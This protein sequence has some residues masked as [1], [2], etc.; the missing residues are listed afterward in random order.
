MPACPRKDVF[1]PDTVGVYHCWNR[2][3]RRAW[4]CGVDPLT[5]ADYEHRRTWIEQ[6]QALLAGLFAI[7]IG[8][9]AELSNH[10][11]L[12]LRNRP[13]VVETWS[14]E[15]VARRVLIINRLT[16]NFGEELEEPS[17]GAIQI[18]LADPEKVAA[19]RR[20]LSDISAFMASLDEYI[21]RRANHEEGIGGTFWEGRFRCRNLEDEAAILVC[22]VYVDL[23]Q[24]RA[25]EAD[26]PEQSRH[27]SAYNRIRGAHWRQD[28]RPAETSLTAD[29]DPSGDA[30]I[31]EGG[32]RDAT[33]MPPDGWLCEL[34]LEE[35]LQ[36]DVGR[37]LSS[38]TPW[39]LTDKGILPIRLP[40]Y[41][42]LLDWT[43]RQQ[44]SGKS[45]CIPESLAPILERLHIRPDRWL[46]T[47]K[48]FETLFGRA[49]GRAENLARRVAKGGG[50]WIR[51]AR[52]CAD[53]FT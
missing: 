5:G 39:R 13:D 38:S 2:C 46:H 37:G 45:G 7:E 44:A 40:E 20:R 21:A 31:S 10:I 27:T 4:L 22:G 8:W 42:S 25:G 50:H 16:R 53:A 35:G 52:H 18:A 29:A 6:R 19:Y 26:T 43:G 41:L 24:I 14:D 34:T 23:N 12:I 33:R 51:G 32:R 47:I 36:A 9:H 17:R 49:I 15:E 3:V 11:H 48:H 1:D 28:L 30:S